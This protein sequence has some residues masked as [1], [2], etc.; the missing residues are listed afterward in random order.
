MQEKLVLLCTMVRLLLYYII[1]LVDLFFLLL[2]IINDF[3]ASC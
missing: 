2:N 3:V 1:I